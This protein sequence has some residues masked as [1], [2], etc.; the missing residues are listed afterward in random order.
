MVAA[1]AIR[2][3]LSVV[4]CK[5]LVA[6]LGTTALVATKS[7]H[8]TAESWLLIA[9]AA[10]TAAVAVLELDADSWKV[11]RWYLDTSDSSQRTKQEVRL[12]ID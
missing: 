7:L 1:T 8:A 2:S 4:E 6:T 11:A 3:Q 9:V 10:A 5:L 12:L